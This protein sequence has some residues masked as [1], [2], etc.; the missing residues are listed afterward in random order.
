MSGIVDAVLKRVESTIVRRG[1]FRKGDGIVVAV[2]GG[3][4]SMAT[5]CILID[6]APKW[7]WRFAVAHLHHGIRGRDADEEMEL[8]ERTAERFGLP[9]YGKKLPKGYLKGLKG[10]LHENARRERYGFLKDSTDRWGGSRVALGHQADDQ[11]ETVLAAL[12]RGA[13]TRG[14]RGMP[15]MKEGLYARPLLDVT[16][17]EI[18]GYLEAASVP[19]GKDPSN[20]D[21]AYLR[22]RI[23]RDLLPFL[24][25]GF[26]PR[27]DEALRRTA[28]I[29]REE[30]DFLDGV[31]EASW[32]ELADVDEDAVAIPLDRY[33]VLHPAVRRRLVRRAFRR[34]CGDEKGLD[35][36]QSAEADRLAVTAAEECGG[37]EKRLYFPRGV[38]VVVSGGVLLVSR[39]GAL[40]EKDWTEP[41][42]IPGETVLSEAGIVIVWDILDGCSIDELPKGKDCVYLNPEALSGDAILRNSRPGDRIRPLGLGGTRKVRDILTDAK[43]PRRVRWKIPVMEDDFGIAWVV[44]LRLDE[45]MEVRK[46]V[47]RIVRARV[48]QS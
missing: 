42:R 30:D 1:L 45:R 22:S 44:G 4:D 13:G 19:Y 31:A 33:R 10:S 3:P 40:S 18:L 14:L 20:E 37:E 15:Y 32:N 41:V 5:L 21:R 34:L 36:S 28:E 24:R 26:N 35:L 29:C 16:R 6:L 47:N 38:R 12:V 46:M 48:F 43:I 27:M 2:S 7:D 39:E 11:S 8:V 23:R 25:D 9:F 17:S